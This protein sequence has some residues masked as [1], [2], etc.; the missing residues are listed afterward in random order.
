MAAALA[1]AIGNGSRQD[2]AMADL[3]SARRC[4]D[5]GREVAFASARGHDA[6]ERYIAA[7]G[8]LQDQDFL[9]E[10]RRFTAVAAKRRAERL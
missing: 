3:A 4:L 6:I 1:Q 8:S 10:W 5:A 9:S 2:D 7:G